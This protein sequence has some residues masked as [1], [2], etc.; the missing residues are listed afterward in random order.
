MSIVFIHFFNKLL[1]FFE[2]YVRMLAV[3]TWEAC[4]LEANYIESGVRT[5]LILA[6]ISELERRGIKDFSLRR[7]ALEAQVS[8]AAPYRH[9]K[10]KEEFIVEIIKYIGSHW[11]LMCKQ[12]KAVYVDDPRRLVIELAVSNLRFWLANPNYRTVLMMSSSEASVNSESFI[13]FEEP[14]MNAVEEYCK[15][16]TEAKKYTL[17][18]LIY[19]SLMLVGKGYGAEEIAE[20]FREKVED[21]FKSDLLF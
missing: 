5:R 14:L 3:L 11:A 13:N 1:Y 15:E 6:G 9:F 10:D 8:C 2:I 19:G 16:N 18:S 21:E 20:L 12:I 17:R 7:V 4:E